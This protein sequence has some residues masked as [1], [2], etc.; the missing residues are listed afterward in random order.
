[1]TED[2][3]Q[4]MLR[5]ARDEATTTGTAVTVVGYRLS[6]LVM[7]NPAGSMPRGLFYV[8][9]RKVTLAVAAAAIAESGSNL[10]V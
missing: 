9:G 8:H 3:A 6:V 4:K 1:M 10:T 7:P 2:T 5:D